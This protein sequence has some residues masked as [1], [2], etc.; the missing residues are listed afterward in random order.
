M[1]AAHVFKPN[2]QIGDR[3]VL[4]RE[5]ADARGRAL[6]RT[7]CRCGSESLVAASELI[8]GRQARCI[9][10]AAVKRRDGRPAY[11][12]AG[13]YRANRGKKIAAAMRVYNDRKAR[14]ICVE[15]GEEPAR[16]GKTRGVECAEYHR[17]YDATRRVA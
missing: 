8:R 13:N 2:E 7:R 6:W 14:G 5:G 9:K 16:P 4:N 12:D 3:I 17:A 15:C 1:P 10:C 11:T